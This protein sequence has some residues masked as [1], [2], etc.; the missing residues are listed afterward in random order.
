[1]FRAGNSWWWVPIVAPC[2]G[3]VLGAWVY[4]ALVGD[5]FP[6]PQRAAEVA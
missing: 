5:R 6:E 1:V 4:D 3:G 2:I